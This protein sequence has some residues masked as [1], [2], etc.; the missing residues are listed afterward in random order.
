MSAGLSRLDR[1]TGRFTTFRHDPADPET[2]GAPGVMSLLADSRGRIW[3]GTF[4]GGLSVL[5]RATGKFHRYLSDAADPTT[6]STNRATALAEDPTGR[7]WVGTETGGLCLLDPASGRFTRFK[8]RGDDAGQLS[9]NTV[10]AIHVDPEGQVWIGTRGG[11]VDQ[12]QGSADR[13]ESIH[14]R[15]YSEAEGLP[16]STVYGVESDAA[17][18]LWLSTNRGLVRLDPAS[19]EV[20]S[21]RQADGL[22]GDE[23]NFGA[24]Y[25]SANGELFFGGPGGYNAFVPERLQ[26]DEQAPPVVLTAFLKL[27]EPAKTTQPHERLRSIDLGYRD[28]VVTFEFAALDFTSPADNRYRYKLDG[29]DPDWVDAGSKRRVT[30]TNLAGGHYTFRV[31]AA[32]SDGK[33]NDTGLVLPLAV[34]A[35][36]WATTWARIGYALALGLVIFAVWHSQQRKL[37]REAQYARRL[38]QDVRDRTAEVAQR[39]SELEALNRQL[40]EASLTDPLTGL[41]NRRS[42]REAMPALTR[43]A[44]DV[45][46]SVGDG[47]LALLVVDLDNL[48]PINDRYG[49]EAGD[50]ILTQIAEILRGCCRTGDAIVRWGGD[51]FVIAYRDADAAAAEHLAERIRRRV[52]RQVFRL[53]GGNVT[54]T[55]CSIGFTCYPFVAEAPDFL[56][57]EQTLAVADAALYCAKKER[58]GWVGWTGSVPMGSGAAFVADLA[59]NSDALAREGKLLVRRPQLRSDDTIDE[60]L[61]G[62]LREGDR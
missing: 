17:N 52:A 54:R 11:G 13:P 40:R 30:Y 49:H 15:T 34:E 16:N 1:S 51:E 20:R 62:V 48:K 21:F 58:N 26:F 38:A 41:G 37:L 32:N 44:A 46:G 5:D 45:T 29:F 43:R 39:N 24:H 50:Q 31:K 9:S 23:F 8:H 6:L 7:I 36:P 2:L 10:Y 19:G 56:T 47:R 57:W 14:F 4:G 22:Q 55:S 18:R 28:D 12:V 59:R 33:W 25:R 42:L 60:L 35:P 3:A 53:S 27:N 61:T